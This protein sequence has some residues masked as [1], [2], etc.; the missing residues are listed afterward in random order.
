MAVYRN[1]NETALD[2]QPVAPGTTPVYNIGNIPP[3]V[4]WTCVIGD[5][6]SFRIYVEDD[7]GNELDYDTTSTGD[8]TGWDISGDF[9]RY[10]DNVGDDLLFTVY[11]DQTEFDDAGEFTVTLSPAQSKILR[12]GDVFDIQL[13]DDTRVWTVCQGEMIMIGEVTEQDTVS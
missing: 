6:A 1:P 10:S 13:R 7:Q 9:R 2:P 11:P 12:T 8:E 5:S 4:N 3:L